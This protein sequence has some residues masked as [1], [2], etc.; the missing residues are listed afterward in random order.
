MFFGGENYNIHKK[1]M[2]LSVIIPIY[3]VEKYL[4]ECIDSVLKQDFNDYELILI[5]DGSTDQSGSICDYYQTQDSRIKVIHKKNGG[6][7]S[8]RN[9][10]IIISKGEY[11]LFLDSDDYLAENALQI[12]FH[13]QKSSDANVVIANF[14]YLYTQ[15]IEMA[16]ICLLEKKIISGKEAIKL[17]IKGKIQNFA[18]GKMIKGKIA[19]SYLFPEGRYFEDTY[20]FHKIIDKGNVLIIPEPLIYYR[21][22]EGSISYSGKYKLKDR[23]LGLEEHYK[24]L[25]QYHP[26]FVNL[27]KEHFAKDLVNISWNF[28]ILQRKKRKEVINIVRTIINQCDLLLISNKDIR[29]RLY[30]LKKNLL[31]FSLIEFV[32][33]AKHK[34]CK[35]VN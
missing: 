6:L 8:A 2:Y 10:G 35:N 13:E 12:F 30:W 1:T 14:Y 22:R 9:A 33:K 17:L 3:N 23:V 21:Q 24:Y 4:P 29:N 27:F 28:I 31:I 11:V 34:I 32:N 18:W 19:R 16:K 26:E 15:K 5:D 25:Q 20:W 7:S